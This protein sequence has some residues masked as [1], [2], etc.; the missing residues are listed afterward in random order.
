MRDDATTGTAAEA[1]TGTTKEKFWVAAAQRMTEFL[2][3]VRGLVAAFVALAGVIAQLIQGCGPGPIV[4]CLNVELEFPEGAIALTQ[5]RE[6]EFRVMGWN[7]CGRGVTVHVAIKS[8]DPSFEFQLPSDCPA[9]TPM[10][11]SACWPEQTVGEGEVEWSVH[12][13][14]LVALSS[15]SEGRPVSA[16]NGTDEEGDNRVRV[17][18]VVYSEQGQVLDAETRPV[19][20]RDDRAAD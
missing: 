16:G 3:S 12:L 4:D 8:L 18:G 2:T 6:A 20:I 15:P 13:P 5:W 17:K 14:E 11:E 1:T 19:R 10:N 7:C 9:G